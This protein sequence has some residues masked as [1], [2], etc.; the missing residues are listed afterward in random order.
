VLPT[1]GQAYI[2]RAF[3]T[4]IVG[5][6]S[7][8][9]GTAAASSLLGGVENIVSYLSTPF[10]GQA[11][12]LLRSGSP[13]AEAFCYSR[14]G[15]AHGWTFGTLDPAEIDTAPLLQRAMNGQAGDDGSTCLP[16]CTGLVMP[17]QHLDDTSAH[18]L[19]HRQM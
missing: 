3:M 13:M 9:T 16:A 5:G 2:A 6:S 18:A 8:L 4:V 11:A 1:M 12:L 14:L 7:V 10:F 15:G 19:D 17:M